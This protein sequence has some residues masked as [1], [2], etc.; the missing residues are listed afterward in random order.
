VLNTPRPG[1]HWVEQ[2]TQPRHSTSRNTAK[3][4][5]ALDAGQKRFQRGA[6]LAQ[7]GL[8]VLLA[9]AEIIRI[10]T[11]REGKATARHVTKESDHMAETGAQT[12]TVRTAGGQ[13]L[14]Y[15][16]ATSLRVDRRG[17]L[18]V[19]QGL[20]QGAFHPC[21]EWASYTVT[22]LRRQRDR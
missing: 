3:A 11:D 10:R 21:A 7:D 19:M 2:V 22:N 4:T 12:V 18:R 6:H 13:E 9:Q 8:R 20:R 5:H 17:D 16:R 15:P 14:V 1:H